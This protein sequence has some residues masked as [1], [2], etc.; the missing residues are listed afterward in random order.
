MV[1][2]RIPYTPAS[3]VDTHTTYVP[4]Q[5]V[6][7][8][9]SSLLGSASPALS[10][11]EQGGDD[12]TLGEEDTSDSVSKAN[13]GDGS[14]VFPAVEDR[15]WETASTHGSGVALVP[16]FNW[17]CLLHLT[18]FVRSALLLLFH[19][20]KVILSVRNQI[21][22][23]CRQLALLCLPLLASIQ[24]LWGVLV[25]LL[26]SRWALW[27]AP[28]HVPPA[29]MVC[30]KQKHITPAAVAVVHVWMSLGWLQCL[31]GRS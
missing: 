1:E 7:C 25:I 29:M 30:H 12:F 20:I 14:G 2:V 11:W 16:P 8:T 24:S 23:P 10:E 5:K 4:T 15:V 3:T 9:K 28:E 26:F 17:T 19:V 6:T 27:M 31:P 21:G 22:F 13:G 18:T